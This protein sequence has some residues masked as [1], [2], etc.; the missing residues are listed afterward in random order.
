M[1]PF[2]P[3]ICLPLLL[4]AW[5]AALHVASGARPS[6]ATSSQQQLQQ[7]QQ[8]QQLAALPLP[9]LPHSADQQLPAAGA[10]LLLPQQ[11][12]PLGVSASGGPLDIGAGLLNGD[13][14]Q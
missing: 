13:T 9:Q 1:M 5:A 10:G 12:Q 8:A 2:P 11:P 3:T 6:I 7:Q 14:G 4:A